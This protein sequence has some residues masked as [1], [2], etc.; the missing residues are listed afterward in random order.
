MSPPE[1]LTH[2]QELIGLALI[3]AKR[4][5]GSST[6]VEVVNPVWNGLRRIRRKDA[7]F[8]IDEGRA[9]WLPDGKIRLLNSHAKNLNAAERAAEWQ[10]QWVTEGG[11]DLFTDSPA[12]HHITKNITAK[13]AK[14]WKPFS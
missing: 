3:G 9:M 1:A 4:Q 7:E 2:T 12:K 10:T 13:G 11:N 8:Y 14:H 5:P 6:K